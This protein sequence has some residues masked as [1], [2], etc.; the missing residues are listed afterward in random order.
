MA[1]F[2]LVDVGV[3]RVERPP[4]V[5]GGFDL[6][7]GE[8]DINVRFPIISLPIVPFVPDVFKNH[9]IV[10][11]SILA[12][13][14]CSH[15]VIRG[16]RGFFVRLCHIAFVILISQLALDVVQRVIQILEWCSV[17]SFVDILV[18]FVVI[19]A[20][21]AETVP[22]PPL[23]VENIRVADIQIDGV[24]IG[25]LHRVNLSVFLVSFHAVQ[26]AGVGR[27]RFFPR[28]KKCACSLCFTS[29]FRVEHGKS[30]FFCPVPH[31]Q[32]LAV[33]ID[34]LACLFGVKILI[35]LLDKR[36]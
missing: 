7:G 23:S 17:W 27:G 11:V 15:Y 26:C 29:A 16:L 13:L 2:L 1:L 32:R 33:L 35:V 22:I 28:G 30:A 36:E 6:L 3:P 25:P 19:N 21:F 31:H 14:N 10:A 4:V 8:G 12:A 24:I 18:F 9:T 34:D 5:R 20:D